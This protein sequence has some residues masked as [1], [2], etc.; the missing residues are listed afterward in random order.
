MYGSVFLLRSPGLLQHRQ[1]DTNCMLAS[2]NPIHV[3]EP[4]LYTKQFEEELAFL[5]N[6]QTSVTVEIERIVQENAILRG[7]IADSGLSPPMTG[8]SQ[9]PPAIVSVVGE[10]GMRKRLRVSV[11]NGSVSM[12]LIFPRDFAI[13]GER[14][15]ASLGFAQPAPLLPQDQPPEFADLNPSANPT[16]WMDRSRETQ[17][18]DHPQRLDTTQVESTSCSCTVFSDETSPC[19]HGC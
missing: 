18:D 8:T 3:S 4:C 17:Q 6:E 11:N 12:P 7:R 13:P 10:P 16:V 1:H 9:V 14:R 15:R 5:Q 19:A 2:N